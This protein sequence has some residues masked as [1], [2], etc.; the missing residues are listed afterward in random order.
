MIEVVRNNHVS[1]DPR[2][3]RSLG[4]IVLFAAVVAALLCPSA[5]A[6]V[7]SAMATDERVT[8]ANSPNGNAT[9]DQLAIPLTDQS[10]NTTTVDQNVN[11]TA[12]DQNGNATATDQTGSA[13][14]TGSAVMTAEQIIGILQQSPALLD[15]VKGCRGA[16]VGGRP[17]HDQRRCTV[18][19]HSA[20][21]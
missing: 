17:K 13:A 5:I 8:I 15:S 2:R 12:T 11:T 10:G 9:A 16:A 18:R 3:F 14:A 20:K 1:S 19:P 21:C 6:Q 4:D 7:T